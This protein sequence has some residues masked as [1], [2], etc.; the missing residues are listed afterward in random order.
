MSLGPIEQPGSIGLL[1]LDRTRTCLRDLKFRA[2]PIQLKRCRGFASRPQRGC[3]LTLLAL[4]GRF[5]HFAAWRPSLVGHRIGGEFEALGNQNDAPENVS[6]ALTWD[7]E[8][9][10]LTSETDYG[11]D[12]DMDQSF[13]VTLNADGNV[14]TRVTT[15]TGDTNPDYRSVE[16]Y[17]SDD[18]LQTETQD[19][20][21]DDTT[22]QVE[23]MEWDAMG[24]A[25]LYSVDL[26]GDGIADESWAQE[27]DANGFFT[28]YRSDEDN[29]GVWDFALIAESE[30]LTE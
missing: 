23:A 15:G 16:V 2:H 20:Y 22:D 21:A 6:T 4:V 27:F 25:T 12:G 1:T 11:N 28:S 3:L 29:N 13:E 19:Y 9:N 24:N 17:S 26:N 18:L 10:I 14:L 8:G 7:A 30:C 5:L